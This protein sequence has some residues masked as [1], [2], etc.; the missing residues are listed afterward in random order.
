MRINEK[1]AANALGLLAALYYSICAILVYVASNLYKSI[2]VSWAHGADVSQIWLNQPP[3][4]GSIIWG[5]I[6]FTVS[7]WITGYMFAL[8]YNYFIKGK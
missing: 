4:M 6:T 2:A 8:L 7:A 3:S 5:F 1:A